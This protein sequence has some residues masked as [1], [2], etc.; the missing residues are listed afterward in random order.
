[1]IARIHFR[2]DLFKTSYYS[3]HMFIVCICY[4]KFRKC[5][6][7][8]SLFSLLF[9]SIEFVYIGCLHLA[10]DNFVSQMLLAKFFVSYYI[11]FLRYI[12]KLLT[13]SVF[14]RITRMKKQAVKCLLINSFYCSYL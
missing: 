14:I 9:S 2:T 4:L 8:S 11:M 13:E 10:R 3:L 7:F 12:K 6:R 1:M 5:R